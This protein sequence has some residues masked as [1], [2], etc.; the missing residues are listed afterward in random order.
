[1]QHWQGSLTS[2][3][4]R[5]IAK[6]WW[7]L[8]TL[9]GSVLPGLSAD[10]AQLQFWRFDSS[11][12][13][14]VFSTDSSVRPRVQLIPGPTRLVVDLPGIQLQ[15]P[16]VKQNLAGTVRSVRVG[17]FDSQTTRI[18]VELDPNYVIDPAGVKV[19]GT[20]PTNWTIDLPVPQRVGT[21][22]VLPSP[23]SVPSVASSP[24]QLPPLQ[25]LPSQ[26]S[27]TQ[28]PPPTRVP[29]Q[30]SP[31]QSLPPAPSPVSAQPSP[32]QPYLED[33][34]V[35]PDG[36][37]LQ[38]VG[39][40]SK[41]S[42]KRSRSRRQ[43][44]VTLRDMAANPK[45]T[46]KTFAPG[47]F[48]LRELKVKQSKGS[49][50]KTE[51][52]F[53]IDKSGSSWISSTSRF[54]VVLV[55]RKRGVSP[56]R[57]RSTVSLLQGISP[58]VVA[59]NSAQ[60]PTVQAVNLGGD[61]LLVQA[62]SPISFATGWEGN[63][64]RLTIRSGA[65]A[66]GIQPPRVGVGSP[67]S[68]VKFRQDPAG[69]SILST[70][71][72]GVRVL[73][74]QRLS[75]NSLILKLSRPGVRSSPLPSQF[76]SSPSPT[77]VNPSAPLPRPGRRI[78]VIDPGHGGR[79]PGAIGINGL[80]ET[81]V[82]LP[83]S[84]DVSRILQQQGVTVYL[85]RTNEREVDL[86]PRVALAERARANVFV[87]IHANA[88]SMSRPDVNGLETYYA[89]GSSAGKRLAQTIHQSIL[90]SIRMGD[91]GVRGARFYVIRRTSMPAA[92]VETGFLTG[93]QDNP[94]LAD[95]NFRRQM[96]QAIARGILQY[97]SRY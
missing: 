94:R 59:S 15:R 35:T 74:V 60:G 47:Y 17:Q 96:A 31:R 75:A 32:S 24:S 78:V 82:V 92:L 45:L 36:L 91:R 56:A 76:P 6:W 51:I 90:S 85:T 67:L 14:L 93:A 8:P 40:A 81:N 2:H 68:R 7:L 71:S 52:V 19:Q 84:L 50:P 55:P 39:T 37:F 57:P 65:L 79:D 97:L 46:E 22:A 80:R 70:P 20:S 5:K 13:R 49:K 25:P 73:G 30:S 53:Q 72:R 83:I 58:A 48:G 1:M 23:T 26:S 27:P 21:T 62:N 64:Y 34:S 42:I 12:N 88:I 16:T 28:L 11:Q 66:S 9:L 54:G 4:L 3:Q 77:T 87:S 43:V 61:Q 86:A 18:V 29:P 44:T 33:I 41:I 89:P 38:T 10:A 95:P 69:F 63:Q